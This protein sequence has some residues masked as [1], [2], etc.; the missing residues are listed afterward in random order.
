MLKERH[1]IDTNYNHLHLK[2]SQMQTD[3]SDR[4]EKV[5][6]AKSSCSKYLQALKS[7]ECSSAVSP[8]RRK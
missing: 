6:I 4:K 5:G 1:E 8:T 7:I 3:E 2:Y